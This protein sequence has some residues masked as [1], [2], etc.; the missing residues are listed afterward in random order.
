MNLSLYYG[1]FPENGALGEYFFGFG[2]A[3]VLDEKTGNVRRQD[4]NPGTIVLNL[5]VRDS[6][7]MKNSTLA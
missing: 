7:S 6:R 4:I 5:E 1:A 3:E 2:T